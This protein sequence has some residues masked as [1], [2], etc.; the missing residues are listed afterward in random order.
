MKKRNNA[1]HAGYSWDRPAQQ[2]VDVEVLHSIER[3]NVTA[4]FG[5]S[6]PPAGLSGLIRRRAFRHSESTYSHW[7]PL[8]LADRVSVFEGIV[9]DLAHARIPTYSPSAAGRLSGDTTGEI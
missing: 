1:E 5:R 2:P 9:R 8:V 3:S 6:T 4:V 7:L